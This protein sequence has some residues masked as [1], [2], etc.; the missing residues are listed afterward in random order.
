MR[1][2]AFHVVAL[3]LLAGC[4][5]GEPAAKDHAILL[6]HRGLE[7][8]AILH[9]PPGRPA[10]PLP[11]V[12]VLHG[13]GTS[14]DDAM[15]RTAFSAKADR[16]G[17]L[18]V[19]PEGTGPLRR[20]L[21]TWNAA[22]C[23]GYA[24][25]QEVDD[26]GFLALLVDTLVAR[27]GADPRR[28]YVAGLSNGAMMAYRAACRLA[29]RVA[30][31]GAVAGAFNETDCRPSHP[32]G[33]AIVHGTADRHILYQGGRPEVAYD[34][35]PRIDRPAAETVAFWAAHNGCPA[36]PRTT[37]VGEVRHDLYTRCQG[38]A[39]VAVFTITGGTHSWPGGGRGGALG[40]EPS[41]AMSATDALWDF[42]RRH[43][44]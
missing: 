30:A 44:R 39:E 28:I 23:C 7:R 6:H 17:F 10:A 1:R 32:V 15:E 42:F 2:P 41:R 24:H 27:Y 11:A 13:S 3:L 29:D 9:A 21:L 26:V 18:A 12:L 37:T 14:S 43:R 31:V 20:R 8:I 19:Y 33:V 35:R 22:N 25:E 36:R 16:E 40:E 34:R 4:A 5:R 38:G